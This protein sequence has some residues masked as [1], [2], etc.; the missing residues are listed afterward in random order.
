MLQGAR[1]LEVLARAENGGKRDKL[2]EEVLQALAEVV[3]DGQHH[4]AITG[5]RRVLPPELLSLFLFSF[6]FSLRVS[7]LISIRH[8][9][10]ACCV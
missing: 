5:S 7:S 8:Q 1:Q 6:F 10:A 3:A 4:D 2:A 9:H